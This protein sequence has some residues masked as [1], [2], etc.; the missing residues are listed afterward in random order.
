MPDCV[1]DAEEAD[2]GDRFPLADLGTGEGFVE[3]GG[4]F[5]GLVEVDIEEAGLY[6]GLDF[7]GGL[8]WLP[9]RGPRIARGLRPCGRRSERISA[10]ARRLG[11]R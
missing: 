11:S 9:S 1:E 8:L 10:S 4:A 6:E 3:I 2:L 5:V 7:D